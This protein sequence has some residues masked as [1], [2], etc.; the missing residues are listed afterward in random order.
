MER[1]GEHHIASRGQDKGRLYPRR[2]AY[3]LWLKSAP[4]PETQGTT[5]TACL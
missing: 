2:K 4:W 5:G 1:V 3:S